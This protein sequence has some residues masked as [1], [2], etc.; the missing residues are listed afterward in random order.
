MD[1]TDGGDSPDNQTQSS[2]EKIPQNSQ[3]VERVVALSAHCNNS[4]DCAAIHAPPRPI[5][6]AHGSKNDPERVVFGAH[7][8]HEARLPRQ[9][10]VPTECQPILSDFLWTADRTSSK[11]AIA[12]FWVAIAHKPPQ[13][14]AE[15]HRARSADPHSALES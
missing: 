6:G 3:R 5:A 7:H 4:K 1:G 8:Q 14:T 13:K 11:P 12:P 2:A 15:F 10:Y 9:S